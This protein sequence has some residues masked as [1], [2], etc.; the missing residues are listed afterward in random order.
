[1]V[2]CLILTMFVKIIFMSMNTPMLDE[3]WAPFPIKGY[4]DYTVSNYGRVKS[5]KKNSVKILKWR[6]TYKNYYNVAPFKADQKTQKQFYIHRLVALAFIPNPNKYPQVNHKN[7]N[8]ADNHVSN[9][10]WC[11][12]QFNKDHAKENGL[13]KYRKGEESHLS[14]LKEKDVLQIRDKFKNG[15]T[16][17]MLASQF[18]LKFRSIYDIVQRR[19]WKHI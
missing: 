15:Y 1:M 14:R 19:C 12:D 11:N 9:L 7:C 3:V 2:R 10:E 18:G 16:A 17:K 5:M 6:E 13:I 4:P 8:K